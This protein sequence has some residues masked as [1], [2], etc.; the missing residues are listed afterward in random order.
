MGPTRVLVVEDEAVVALNL[1]QQLTKLGYEVSKIVAS[2]EQALLQAAALRPDLILMDINI[3]GDTDGIETASQLRDKL[4]VPIIYLTAYAEEKTLERARATKPYGYLVKPYSERELHATIQMG[5][6]RHHADITLRAS[7]HLLEQLT[8][9]LREEVEER[10]KAEAAVT[11]TA[12]LL[13]ATFDAAPFPIMVTDRAANVLMWNSAGNRT[14]GYDSRQMVGLSCTKLLPEQERQKLEAFLSETSKRV[15]R[16]SCELLCCHADGRLLT[17]IAHSAPI[18]DFDRGL[19]AIV[20]IFEDVTERKA[21]DEQLRQSQKMEAIGN[22]TGGMAH[23]F[24]NILGVVIGNLDLLRDERPDDEDLVTLTGEAIDAAL[25]G[26]DLTRRLLAFARRQPLQPQR[27]AI[28][29]FVSGL[30]RLLTRVLGENIEI[31]VDFSDRVC[32]VVAD[33]AQLS[34]ALTNLATN[35]RDAMPHGG[36]L[37]IATRDYLLESNDAPPD[38][39]F[40]PGRYALIEVTD[41]GCGIAPESLR[42]IFEPFYSTKERDKGTGLGLSMVFGFLKQSRGHVTV[43]SELGK[44]TTFKLYLPC[45]TQNDAPL[46]ENASDQIL[47]PSEGET[48]LVVDD[49]NALRHAVVRQLR[50]LGYMVAEAANANEAMALLERKNINLVFTDVIMP[51]EMSGT[52]LAHAALTRWPS[53]KFVLTSGS[54]NVALLETLDSKRLRLLVKPYRK[55][56][57]AHLLRDVLDA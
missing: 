46:V 39:D 25:R 36:K 6:E 13:R 5:L 41:T 14:F 15:S 57:L 10:K 48:I 3:Q 43:E 30:V 47:R 7:H 16:H 24:N 4:Q 33:P 38:S 49:N 9:G 18:F 51:G 22:L 50:V 21:I 34:S 45:S 19:T 26:A 44:G 40:A 20:S 2:G 42:H 31:S 37:T 29:E 27:I 54:P 8:E 55:D 11:T 35:A 28:N 56:A 1:K 53:V 12:D 17:V 52:D 32:P 23:D